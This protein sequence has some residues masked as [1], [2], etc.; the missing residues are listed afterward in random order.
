LHPLAKE[1]SVRRVVCVLLILLTAS[2]AASQESE[3]DREHTQW[4]GSVIRTTRSIQPGMT[5]ADL[6]KIFTTQGGI[7]T[8][9]H[10]TYVLRECV[11]IQVNVDFVAIEDPD[12]NE[13]LPTD[14]IKA[15]SLPFLEYFVGD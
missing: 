8:R 3:V 15:I 14:E 12:G 4:I 9:F 7:S 2:L 11:N 1:A 13:E 10:R 5:R 6:L